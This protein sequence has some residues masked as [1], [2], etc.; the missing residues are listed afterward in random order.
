MTIDFK[1]LK[2]LDLTT[3]SVGLSIIG[4]VPF[5]FISI[6]LFNRPFFTDNPIWITAIF[7]FCFSTLWYML[8]LALGIFIGAL[9]KGADIKIMFLTGGLISIIYLSIAIFGLYVLDRHTCIKISFLTFLIV[10][11]CYGLWRIL[12]VF[13]FRKTIK[14]GVKEIERQIDQEMS[15]Q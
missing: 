3:V 13:L 1:E 2:Q 14:Q 11:Y 7:C 15:G 8:N 4:L 9:F 5:W 10:A 6:F 12:F